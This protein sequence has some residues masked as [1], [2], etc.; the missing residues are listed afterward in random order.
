MN[1]RDGRRLFKWTRPGIR[2]NIED[3]IDRAT[4]PFGPDAFP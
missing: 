1:G 3:E 4:V 2:D